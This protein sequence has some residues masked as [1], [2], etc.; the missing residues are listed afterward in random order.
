MTPGLLR[1]GGSKQKARTTC[2]EDARHQSWLPWQ[3]DDQVQVT[4]SSLKSHQSERRKSH[5][6][7]NWTNNLPGKALLLDQLAKLKKKTASQS[8][9]KTLF[10]GPQG[11]NPQSTDD[12]S[13]MIVVCDF[14]TQSTEGHEASKAS[15]K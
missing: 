1:P 9:S 8:S 12:D 13:P 15:T 4:R 6:L 11:S 5:T 3:S 7:S 10:T 2:Y 14:C